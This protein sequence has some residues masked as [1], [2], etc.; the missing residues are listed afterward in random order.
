MTEADIKQIN[1][2]LL[3]LLRGYDEVFSQDVNAKKSY[4][5]LEWIWNKKFS[6][7]FSAGNDGK[8]L[9]DLNK[10]NCLEEL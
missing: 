8:I 5:G 9:L 6:R 3:V 4:I 7:I 10:I 1:P 2:E